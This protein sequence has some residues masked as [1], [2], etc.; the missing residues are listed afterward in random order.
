[1]PLRFQF[2]GKS[3]LYGRLLLFVLFIC[4]TVLISSESAFLLGD[5]VVGPKIGG[6]V[7]SLLLV[8]FLF[9]TVELL[10][11][12]GVTNPRFLNLIYIY[13]VGGVVGGVYIANPFV[14]VL[15]Y[16]AKQVVYSFFHICNATLYLVICRFI[17]QDIFRSEE[18]HSDHIWGA[19]VVYFLIIIF[20]GDL[21][22]IIT[23]ARPGLLGQVYEIGWPNYIQCLMYSMNAISGI[24]SVYP[25]T[26]NLIKKLSV[27][28]S[29]IGNL[30]LVVILGRLLSHPLRKRTR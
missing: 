9:Y 11:V 20:F 13:A 23:L 21:F 18:T 25:E 30:F 24:D 8:G 26:H 1:M 14:D 28:E 22:E 3:N 17:L 4:I 16:P 15:S 12:L 10:K 7:F 2:R 6:T 19:I 29:I 27:L 5:P